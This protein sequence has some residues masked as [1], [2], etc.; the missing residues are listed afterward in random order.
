MRPG[1][2]ETHLHT[3]EPW[4]FAPAAEG[5]RESTLHRVRLDACYCVRLLS[6]LIAMQDKFAVSFVVL[7]VSQKNRQIE[8]LHVKS[9]LLDTWDDEHVGLSGIAD[10]QYLFADF[11][12]DDHFFAH[13]MPFRLS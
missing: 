2:A 3:P 12:C 8:Q 9:E 13:S 5:M 11:L 7:T 1:A 4:S 6:F 10:R